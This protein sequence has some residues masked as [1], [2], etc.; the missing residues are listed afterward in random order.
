MIFEIIRSY[1]ANK[2]VEARNNSGK[3][4]VKINRF[5][6]KKNWDDYEYWRKKQ[7]KWMMIYYRYI[8]FF[9]LEDIVKSRLIK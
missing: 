8:H 9:N 7:N 1:L 6:S 3:A 5:K 4:T 2:V